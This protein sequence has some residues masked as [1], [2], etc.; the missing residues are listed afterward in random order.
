M[1]SL[2]LSCA[3]VG[4]SRPPEIPREFR[5][6]WVAT[7]ANIDW[8]SPKRTLPYEQRADLIRILDRAASLKLNT[9]ILQVRPAADAL[10]QSAIEP[11][12]VYLTGRQ[13]Q[14][15]SPFYDPLE[16]AVEEAHKRGLQLH[17][18]FNPYRAQLLTTKGP[19][20][21]NHIA[22]AH[23]E[24]V[25]KYADLLWM[26]PGEPRVRQRSLD[27]ILD[28]VKRYDID[29]VHLDDYFYPYPEG[30][31]PFPDDASYAR[32][33]DGR[34]KLDWRHRNVDEF[35][36]T[37]NRKIHTLKP[38]VEFGISPFGIYR[39]GIPAGIKAG[40]DQYNDLSSDPVKWLQQGWCDYLSPQLYWPIDQKAQ[41]FPVL[42]AWWRS[43]NSLHRHLWPGLYTSR[44]F[45]TRNGFTAQEVVHQVQVTR[46]GT[47]DPGEIHF[48]MK[49]FTDDGKGI[50]EYLLGNCYQDYAL[51]P[52]SPW[53]DA[54]APSAPE[55]SKSAN[56]WLSW[57][58]GSDP[59]P[60]NYVVLARYGG[61][62]QY[63]I[64]P[65]GEKTTN[66]PL[67]LA[68]GRL[69]RVEVAAVSRTGVLGQYASVDY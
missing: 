67:N 25:K 61:G 6:V 46:Q 53:L 24:L 56:G 44:V 63:R 34:S 68:T 5:G 50:D 52:A 55:L 32:Y 51:A 1:L 16:F 66:L 19:L 60:Q 14:P 27:V 62:W 12:S 13:G 37:L 20:A 26:D 8:P 17:A 64:L 69:I 29:G 57:T 21:S 23:P 18:W 54:R 47:T 30:G 33:G 31:K 28:V 65:G 43:Q 2:I 39:P 9:I 45:S 22:I 38:W 36:S 42:L 35:I 41:S 58:A 11:W 15:P 49:A 10:Y 48:S 7:V 3:I 40:V 59:T 4:Q